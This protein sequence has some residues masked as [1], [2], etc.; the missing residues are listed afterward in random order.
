[1]QA[2]ASA[3]PT[4]TKYDGTLPVRLF[5]TELKALYEE[6]NH[7]EKLCL[8]IL[9]QSLEGD[10]KHL[11]LCKLSED[12]EAG[13]TSSLDDWIQWLDT[14]F[15]RSEES[16]MLQIDKRKMKA[17]ESAKEYVTSL[18][19]LMKSLKHPMTEPHIMKTLR[20][21]LL[22]EYRKPLLIMK[23]ESPEEFELCLEKVLTYPEMTKPNPSERLNAAFENLSLAVCA[24]TTSNTATTL[25]A[26]QSH[27]QERDAEDFEDEQE[28]VHDE[29]HDDEHNCDYEQDY[30]HDQDYHYQDEYDYSPHDQYYYH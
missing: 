15:T 13:I 2:C 21:N 16:L 9:R 3:L 27:E 22:P 11:F 1:M 14:Q 5:I 25:N 26:A 28:Y 30:D 10:A 20:D 12:I 4:I 18:I 23:P 19:K 29:Y 17:G 7:D 8:R 24:P 6:V